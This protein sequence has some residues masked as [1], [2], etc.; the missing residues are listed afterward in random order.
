MLGQKTGEEFTTN[1]SGD[2]IVSKRQQLKFDIKSMTEKAEMIEFAETSINK[3][4]PLYLFTW[5]PNP[6]EL[7]DCDFQTQHDHSTNVVAHFLQSFE[8]GLACVESTQMGNPH[9]HGWYQVSEKPILVK[10]NIAMVKTLKRLGNLKIT[11]SLGHYKIDSYVQ[12]ANCLYY[13]KKDVMD[14]MLWVRNNPISKETYAE[15]DYYE[16]QMFFMKPQERRNMDKLK[17]SVKLYAYYEE[18]YT[19]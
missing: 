11:K 8:V 3:D 6:N 15:F 19:K 13:Y 2:T 17:E 16:N 10:L 12:H 1:Q 5:A 7:P 14:S 9:Y 18:F 4:E